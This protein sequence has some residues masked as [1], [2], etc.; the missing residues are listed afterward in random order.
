MTWDEARAAHY[1]PAQAFEAVGIPAGTVRRW[2][3]QG[4]LRPVALGPGG[5]RGRGGR[6][7]R[8][9]AYADVWRLANQ[10]GHLLDSG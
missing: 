4:R 6:P 8:L 10:A 7:V 2:A 3:S 1:W 9:Y 5:G